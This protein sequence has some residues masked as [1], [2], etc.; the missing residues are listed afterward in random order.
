MV[1]AARKIEIG[2]QPGPQEQFLASPADIVIY[3]GAAGG[4]KS[5]GL[6]LEPLRHIH[7]PD[8]G[9]VCFRR[10]AV[11]IT[12]QG[13]LWDE[14]MGLYRGAGG[15]PR[16]TPRLEW[17]FSSGA[18]IQFAH[19][20]HEKNRFDWQGSQI[21]LELWDELTHFL[22]SQFFYLLSRNRSMCGVRPYVRATTNPEA[23]SWVAQ[24][25]AW[26]ID[27]DTGYAIP[28]RSGVLRW[29]VRVNDTIIWGD[30]PEELAEHKD[31]RGDPIP[32]KSLTFIP[33]SL[34]DNPKLMEADP[35]YRA[36]LLALTTVERERLLHGNWKIRPAAGL[37]FQ[38]SWV[39]VHDAAPA[40]LRIVRGWDLAATEEREGTDPDWTT[41]TKMGVTP[42]GHY[43]VLDHCYD[44]LAPG[45][46]EKMVFD[47]ATQDTRKVEIAMRQDPG[48]AGK[49]QKVALGKKLTGYNVRFNTMTGDKV[50]RFSPFS[51]QAEVG[52]VSVVRGSW[53]ER[54][55]RELENF[56]PE[57]HG[58]DDD[59]DSTAEA[60]NALNRPRSVAAVSSYRSMV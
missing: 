53:N 16:E 44:R 43:W 52:N 55:F 48:Q 20:E 5:W 21:A 10:K 23:D 7:N 45:G 11:E 40:N 46:V 24:L 4:G 51:A 60:F 49:S 37:Y 15:V 1:E 59:A 56:P 28:E 36:N 30:S 8:F 39:D 35:G 29:F 13:G 19:L 18:K 34:E 25:I 41:G 2:P 27:Q 32:P 33:A 22:E 42:D 17:K 54:W 57:G 31:D 58:H 9:A 47:V 14:A 6:L 3:G 26:W 50:T 38:R 12:E